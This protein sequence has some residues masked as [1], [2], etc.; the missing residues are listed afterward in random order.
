MS[1]TYHLLGGTCYLQLQGKVFYP[2]YG[3]STFFFLNIGLELL[4]TQHVLP[5]NSFEIQEL[6][7]NELINE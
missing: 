5:N 4:T 1:V 7:Q 6:M 3:C 2:E